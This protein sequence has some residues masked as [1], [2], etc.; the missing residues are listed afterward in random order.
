MRAAAGITRETQARQ[1]CTVV[2]W[3]GTRLR[4]AGLEKQ[5]GSWDYGTYIKVG[6]RGSFLSF[7][8]PILTCAFPTANGT[9]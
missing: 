5:A 4:Y 9:K 3:T 2:P 6:G 1:D 8:V 7:L